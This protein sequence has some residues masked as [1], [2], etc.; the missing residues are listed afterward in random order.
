MTVTMIYSS[1]NPAS[2]LMDIASS[3]KGR[4]SSKFT[5]EEGSDDRTKAVDIFNPNG[6]PIIG[7]GGV[8]GNRGGREVIVVPMEA[9]AELAVWWLR[10]RCGES[11]GGG[12][13]GGGGGGTYG[14]SDGGCR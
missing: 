11:Y 9:T 2:Y 4:M 1:T 8:R 13:G 7:C 5:V 10:R 12:Y 6:N 14:E 3:V